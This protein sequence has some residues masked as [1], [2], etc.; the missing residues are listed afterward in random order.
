M[1]RYNS[2]NGNNYR[3]RNGGGFYKQIEETYGIEEESLLKKWSQLNL[4]FAKSFNQRIFLLRCRK[5]DVVP[6]HLQIL[7]TQTIEFNSRSI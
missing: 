1:S 7:C 4:D 3:G 5:L 2:K 6:K